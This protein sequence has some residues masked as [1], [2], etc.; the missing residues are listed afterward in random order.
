LRKQSNLFVVLRR[1]SKHVSYG[2]LS[3]N[4]AK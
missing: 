2:S 1:Q 3:F 4:G